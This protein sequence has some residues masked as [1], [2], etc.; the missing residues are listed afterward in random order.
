MLHILIGFTLSR[1]ASCLSWPMTT[2]GPSVKKPT[3][4]KNASG[5]TTASGPSSPTWPRRT[6][7][8][9]SEPKRRLER[10]WRNW[11]SCWGW[12]NP[13]RVVFVC[14]CLTRLVFSF[15][16]FFFPFSLV[17]G[18][19]CLVVFSSSVPFL[20][21]KENATLFPC[22]NSPNTR[23]CQTIVHSDNNPALNT[24]KG[25]T[26][27][28]MKTQASLELRK[29]IVLDAPRIHPPCCPTD[30]R[31]LIKVTLPRLNQSTLQNK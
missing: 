1:P 3:T 2:C 13:R 7:Q 26:C 12:S 8:T 18:R 27:H 9:T 31:A 10:S 21:K 25:Y 4:S 20:F 5:S 19:S 23:R 11:T 15:L 22:L 28:A 6:M 16:F 17:P 30:H 14:F 29:Q 24:N